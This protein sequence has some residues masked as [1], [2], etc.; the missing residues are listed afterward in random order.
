[1]DAKC[2]N[3]SCGHEWTLRKAPG[4]Y[5]QGVRCPDC[6]TTDVELDEADDRPEQRERRTPRP[7]PPA[8]RERGE[9][10]GVPARQSEM[11]PVVQ[12]GAQ[13]GDALFEIVNAES[14]GDMLQG[15]GAALFQLGDREKQRE[16][17]ER[18]AAADVDEVRR[19][20]QYPT[21]PECGVAITRKPSGRREFPCPSCGTPLEVA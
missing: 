1:M 6:G 16:V 2:Q 17:R 11:P 8:R 12:Q 18:E 3:E 21:C 19:S 10:G 5:S 4:E 13:G 9:A 20:E 7:D 14:R 15:F